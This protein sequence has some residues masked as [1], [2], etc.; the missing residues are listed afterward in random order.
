[1][2]DEIINLD[3]SKSGKNKQS[4]IGLQSSG[5]ADFIKFVL[6][7]NSDKKTLLQ[8]VQKLPYGTNIRHHIV[9]DVGKENKLAVQN[10]KIVN[11]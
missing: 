11:K 9:G 7:K 8:F 3:F 5:N 1:M 6:T 4:I 10:K 2:N